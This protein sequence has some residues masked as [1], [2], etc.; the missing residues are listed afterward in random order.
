[1]MAKYIDVYI[2]FYLVLSVLQFHLYV[3]SLIYSSIVTRG[4]VDDFLNCDELIQ[5]LLYIFR[6]TTT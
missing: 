5:R 4:D 6:R 2:S 3:Y 1:M